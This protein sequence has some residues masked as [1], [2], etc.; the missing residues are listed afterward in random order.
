MGRGVVS[1]RKPGP[2][3][4]H[5][6]SQVHVTGRNG[7]AGQPSGPLVSRRRIAAAALAALAAA[8]LAGCSG[9][10]QAPVADLPATP[11]AAPAPPATPVAVGETVDPAPRTPAGLAR[12][13]RG[14]DAVVVALVA[15][16]PVPDRAVAH[17]VARVGRTA[18]GSEGVRYLVYRVDR[19]RSF[20]DLPELL[21]IDSTPTVAVIGRD[22]ALVN[23]FDGFVDAGAL[24]QSVDEARSRLPRR[25]P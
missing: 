11:V 18:V 9:A 6:R 13:L 12:A 2:P 16:R 8:A 20:G 19:N 22:G 17:A 3:A 4:S 14:R 21:D 1:V 5:L 10:G 15:S 7:M 24:R 25:T 23:R